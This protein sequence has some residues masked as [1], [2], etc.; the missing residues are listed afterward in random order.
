MHSNCACGRVGTQFSSH[1]LPEAV[2]V[3]PCSCARRGDTLRGQRGVV[4]RAAARGLTPLGVR[5]L[6]QLPSP[7][8]RRG[9]HDAPARGV[10]LAGRGRGLAQAPPLSA[11]PS[12]GAVARGAAALVVG[13]REARLVAPRLRHAP[14]L[15]LADGLLRQRRGRERGRPMAVL[16]RAVA[17][18]VA[19]PRVG[20]VQAAPIAPARGDQAANRRAVAGDP[21]LPLL[22]ALTSQARVDSL[23]A[24]ALARFPALIRI[25][26]LRQVASHQSAIMASLRAAQWPSEACSTFCSR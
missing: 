6:R 22:F 17:H 23:S 13:R 15:A 8:G 21:L 19:L 25:R 24:G 3:I 9:V 20:R 10:R 16:P 14:N 4:T 26:V 18:V 7:L 2:S 11:P 1:Q 5:V 12:A